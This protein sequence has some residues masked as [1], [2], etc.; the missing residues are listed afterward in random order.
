M[1]KELEAELQEAWREISA[2]V[3]DCL[4]QRDYLSFLLQRMWSITPLTP[5]KRGAHEL[6]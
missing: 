2:L 5:A 4:T 6:V 1:D 3:V